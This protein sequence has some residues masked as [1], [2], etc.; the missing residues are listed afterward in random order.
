MTTLISCDLS[1][2]YTYLG[3]NYAG[4]FPQQRIARYGNR[5]IIQGH[6]RRECMKLV[7]S[8]WTFCKGRCTRS[9][10]MAQKTKIYSIQD[11]SRW[12]RIRVHHCVYN[13]HNTTAHALKTFLN[14]SF[15]NPESRYPSHGIYQ[16]RSR[17][18]SWKWIPIPLPEFGDKSQSRSSLLWMRIVGFE[19]TNSL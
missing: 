17:A 8:R 1:K 4:L 10:N 13:I 16:S 12:H 6:E 5:Y 2:N 15:E 14:R 18:Q 9:N 7:I 19:Y 3:R 11:S